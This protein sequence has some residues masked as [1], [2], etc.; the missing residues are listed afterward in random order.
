MDL[1]SGERAFVD[2]ARDRLLDLARSRRD[3]GRV[4]L[5]YAA[6]QS[7]AGPVYTGIPF[8]SSAP[9]FNVC[10]E[11]HAINRLRYAEP[12]GAVDTVLV[13]GPAPDRDAPVTTP[14]GACRHAIDEFGA[15]A[16]VLCS[17]YVREDEGYETFPRI[18]R[19]AASELYPENNPHPTWE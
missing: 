3:A 10:A 11:R 7:T 8:E 14:C 4:D 6:V 1:T 18:E 13:A 9:Q 15:D 5:L 16:T 17:L 2:E 12:G 19:Y